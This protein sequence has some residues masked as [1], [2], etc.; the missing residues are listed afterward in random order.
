M[1]GPLPHSFQI[2][3]LSEN[4]LDEIALE[5][6]RAKSTLSKSSEFAK[7]YQIS[8]ATDAVLSK[9]LFHS[10]CPPR[11]AAISIVK[12]VPLLVSVRQLGSA[13]IELRRFMELTFW[14]IYFEEHPVEWERFKSNP[15]HGFTKDEKDP[16]EYCAHRE[17]EYYVN[18]AKSR[19]GDEPSRLAGIAV[20]QLRILKGRLNEA[21][22]PGS[23]TALASRNVPLDPIDEISLRGFCDLQRAVFSNTCLLMGALQRN[24]FDKLPPMY[25]AYFDWLM[26]KVLAKKIRS[27]AF[28]I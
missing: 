1:A 19:V 20:D 28:G 10:N 26:G 4:F 7:I 25:R 22:H 13:K 2:Q 5:L 14:S 6:K 23:S 11:H 24:R 8:L 18:Y 3:K 9:L 21:V 15:T 27:A 17:L 16:V 12:S